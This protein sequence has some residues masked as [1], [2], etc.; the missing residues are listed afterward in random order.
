M[1]SEAS[2]GVHSD[3][4]K[5]TGFLEAFWRRRETL[6]AVPAAFFARAGSRRLQI[7]KKIYKNLYTEEPDRCRTNRSSG[8]AARGA[9]F[10]RF[11]LSHGGW[12][13]SS[14]G[15]SSTDWI[16]TTGN[17]CKPSD[18]E[19]ARSGFISPVHTACSTWQRERMRSTSF[20]RLRRRRKERA[21]TIC[22]SA[23]I[24]SVHWGN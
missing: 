20:M 16:R 2:T 9:T 5:S 3:P 19:S 17:R 21:R 7:K 18:Q 23:A 13:A 15:A 11:L 8:S 12:P 24:D 4:L 22:K 1:S 10:G 14:F 6:D